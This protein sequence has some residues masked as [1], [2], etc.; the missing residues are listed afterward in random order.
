M[1]TSSLAFLPEI[2][3]VGRMLTNL[4]PEGELANHLFKGAGKLADNAANRALIQ[5]ISNGNALGVD[6]FGKSWYS[7]ID[8]TGKLIY[9]LYSE[10]CCQG[11]RIYDYDPCRN[12]H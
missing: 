1:E 5:T 8:A 2:D 3:V 9:S 11:C 6:A 10:W 12:D 4:I 7:G